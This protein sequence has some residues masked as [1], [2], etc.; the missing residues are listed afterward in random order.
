MAA[1]DAAAD[2]LVRCLWPPLGSQQFFVAMGAVAV[3]SLNCTS[4]IFVFSLCAMLA[5]SAAWLLR[6]V[7]G[8][9]IG[10][11]AVPACTAA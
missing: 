5:G 8:A 10:P 1:L 6:H 2:V 9:G 11:C 7:P 4:P 3:V